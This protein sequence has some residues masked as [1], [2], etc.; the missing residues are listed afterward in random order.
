MKHTNNNCSSRGFSLIEVLV[1]LFV[2][3]IGMLGIAGME[4]FSKQTGS[5]AIQRSTA[6]FLAQEMMGKMRANP[7]GLAAYLNTAIGNASLSTPTT[8]CK[9]TTCTTTDLASYDLWSWE[10]LLDGAT[11]T[12]NSANTGGLV[13]PQA[14]ISGPAAGAAGVYTV[15]IAWRGNTGMGNPSTS[16]CGQTSGLYGS[17]NEFRRVITVNLYISND[18]YS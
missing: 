11:E 7:A 12:A 5:E 1:A 14:C 9:T 10:Q 6:I 18:S 15:A 13:Q 3:S 4:L 16:T 2:I 17:N 8:N